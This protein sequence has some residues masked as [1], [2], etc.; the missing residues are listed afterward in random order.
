M[1]KDKFLR[2][3]DV[4][5]QIPVSRATLY[6]LSKQ[7]KLLRPIKI[8]GSSFWSQ[9]NINNYFENLKKDNLVA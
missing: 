5:I 4:L 9:E 8:G 1:E 7:I 6:R 2:I 3:N